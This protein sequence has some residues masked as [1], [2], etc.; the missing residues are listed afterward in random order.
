[1]SDNENSNF[2]W[3]VFDSEDAAVEAGKSLKKWDKAIKKLSWAPS[4]CCI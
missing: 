2:V 4:A 3:A 1:M